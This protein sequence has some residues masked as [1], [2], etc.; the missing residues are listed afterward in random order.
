M[1][2]S[3]E[4]VVREMLSVVEGD[5]E[6]VIVDVVA[7]TEDDDVVTGME[8][9]VGNEVDGEGMLVD[10]PIAVTVVIEVVIQVVICG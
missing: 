4:D 2:V 7:T 6:I 3:L 1:V 5:A 8:E 9:Y 10:E